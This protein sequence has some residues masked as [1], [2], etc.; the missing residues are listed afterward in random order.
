ML[1]RTERPGRSGIFA[2]GLHFAMGS[3]YAKQLVPRDPTSGVSR[4]TRVLIRL[5]FYLRATGL[6]MLRILLTTVVR[7][8]AYALVAVV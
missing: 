8:S 6:G 5:S 3:L 1:D 4:P 7:C 2:P